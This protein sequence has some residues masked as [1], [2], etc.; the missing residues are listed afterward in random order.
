MTFLILIVLGLVGVALLQRFD[1]FGMI[2]RD[3][4]QQQQ[5]KIRKVI[6]GTR[7]HRLGEY[8]VQEPEPL[9]SVDEIIGYLWS[10][11]HDRRFIER[12]FKDS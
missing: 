7:E 10:L 4:L 2:K 6:P 1:V 12:F 8:D 9:P 11:K 3:I 5:T